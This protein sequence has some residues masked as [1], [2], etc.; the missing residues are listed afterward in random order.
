MSGSTI[1]SRRR[2]RRRDGAPRGGAAR[3]FTL[4]ELLVVVAIIALLLAILMPA[5]ARARQQA[6]WV[7]CQTHLKE[8]G[9]GLSMYLMDSKGVLAGPQHP[10][11][12]K[13]VTDPPPPN[14]FQQHFYLPRMLSK[15]FTG[16]GKGSGKAA[17][18]VSTCPA[19][20]VEDEA[21]TAMANPSPGVDMRPF[22]YVINTWFYTQPQCYFGFSHM[23]IQSIDDWLAYVE[24]RKRVHQD[25]TP[26][27]ASSIKFPSREWAI[28]DAFRK[29]WAEEVEFDRD[30]I[31]HGSWPRDRDP[32]DRTDLN[33]GNPLP[34][35]P[36]HLGRGHE[37][38]SVEGGF[39][40]GYRGR[41]NT[42]YFDWHV[43]SQRGFRG[44][45]NPAP[46]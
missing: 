45:V 23:G 22:H 44:T 35:S 28:A 33:S 14:E 10:A 4:I 6:K 19:F 26:K 3:G 11:M 41:V 32:E 27:K 46:N 8:L 16:S 31:G 15:Y 12:L 18:G 38:K 21:F 40:W 39:V 5:L 25:I 17:E 36:F 29:P 42:L 9:N 20:P 13:N 1:Q 24:N 7:L 30:L 34:N 2:T 37:K 43:E